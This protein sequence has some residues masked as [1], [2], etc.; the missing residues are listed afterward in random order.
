MRARSFFRLSDRLVTTVIT[1]FRS[2]V[3]LNY[4]G[5]AEAL[6]GFETAI[7]KTTIRLIARGLRSASG[8][9]LRGGILF[10]TLVTASGTVAQNTPPVRPKQSPEPI[11]SAQAGESDQSHSPSLFTPLKTQAQESPYKPITPRQ[12]LRWFITNSLGPPHLVG[13]LFTASFGTAVDRPKEYG[14]HWGGFAERYGMRMTGIVTGNA[15]EVGAGL[16]MH[17]DPRYFRVPER[18]FKSRVRNVVRQTFV[19]RR[20][21]GTFGPAY[22]RY[23]AISGNNFLSNTW[24]ADSEA[25]A[26][27]ALWRT[28]EGFAGRMSANAFEEFWPSVKKHIFHAQK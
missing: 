25:N 19:A 3:L 7:W 12:G 2:S 9:W 26:H 21:D 28:A 18:L 8:R 5:V 10:S 27:D 6:A 11:R 24:R 15:M 22:A 4:R 23:F 17:E 16:L 20:D 1:V 13:G 14:P